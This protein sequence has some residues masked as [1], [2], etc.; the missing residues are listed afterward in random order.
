MEDTAYARA[1]LSTQIFPPSFSTI[2]LDKRKAEAGPAIPL[3]G[4]GIDLG[5]FAE[6][7]IHLIGR[8]SDTG[9]ADGDQDEPR[10]PALQDRRSAV[11]LPR[12]LPAR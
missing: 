8:N 12:W 1:R 3:G 9:V 10:A 7:L 11:P 6:D 4:R 5:K 2:C